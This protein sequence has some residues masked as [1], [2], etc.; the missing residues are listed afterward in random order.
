MLP[1]I[2]EWERTSATAL[3]AYVLPVID[4]YL[5]KLEADLLSAGLS[6][7]SADH[8]GQRRLL[9]GRRRSFAGRSMRFIPVPPPRR[10]RRAGF[11]A[12]HRAEDLITVDMGGTSFDVC[13]ITGERRR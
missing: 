3:S 6:A 13:L 1:E 8:A 11:A 12:R 10:P 4:D 2:R 9:S 5:R 7:T